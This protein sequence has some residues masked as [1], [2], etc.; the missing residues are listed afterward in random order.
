M[1]QH[2]MP[3]LVFANPEPTLI[4]IQI[5]HFFFLGFSGMSL[6]HCFLCETRKVILGD[7]IL[8][9]IIFFPIEK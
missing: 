4:N 5:G 6:K 2:Y 7:Q 8:T 9:L 1:L 3:Q